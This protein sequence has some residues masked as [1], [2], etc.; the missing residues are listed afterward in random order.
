MTPTPAFSLRQIRWLP[1]LTDAGPEQVTLDDAFTRAHEIRELDTRDP[2]TRAALHR[3]LITTGALV[4]RTAGVTRRT[5]PAIARDGFTAEQVTAALDTVDD[6]L[7]LI[8]PDTRSCRRRPSPASPSSPSARRT[9]P[10]TFFHRGTTLAE[11]LML[12]T[13]KH[14]LEERSLPAWAG[15]Y[16]AALH[17]GT[18]AGATITGD[19]VHLHYDPATGIFPTVVRGGHPAGTDPRAARDAAKEQLLASARDD[20]SRVTTCRACSSPR[21][22][23][24][25]RASTAHATRPVTSA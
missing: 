11:H 24:G 19:A 25:S 2:V 1:V 23:S 12:N 7:W 17:G 15:P 22:A 18:L 6:H 10:L 21:V 14:W 16:T 5:A 4:A 8:H 13:P 20:I 9:P 3:F